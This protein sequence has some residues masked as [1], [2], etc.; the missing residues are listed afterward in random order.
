MGDWIRVDPRE[1]DLRSPQRLN[2]VEINLL[3]SPYDVPEGVRGAYDESIDRF[4]IEFRYI[5][6]EPWRR[7]VPDRHLALRVGRKSNRLYGIEI[8]VKR[9]RAESVVLRVQVPELVRSAIEQLVR[10]PDARRDNY[11][12]AKD[13]IAKRKDELFSQLA[14]I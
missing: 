1:F 9:L 8:D 4:V 11:N 2:N 12:L 14:S 6:D 3:V 5:G 7:E 13:V 10:R